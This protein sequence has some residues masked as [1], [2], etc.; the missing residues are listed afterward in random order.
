MFV[1]R[2]ISGAI[3]LALIICGNI[4]GGAAWWIFTG[5]LS[6]TA[7]YELFKVLSLHRTAMFYVTLGIDFALYLILYLGYGEWVPAI[8]M[9]YFVLL[10]GLY[11]IRWPVYDVKMISESLFAFVYAGLCMS[12]LYQVRI[13]EYGI[14]FIWIIFIVSWGCDTF[15]YLTGILIGKH[16][17]PTTLSPKKTIEGCIGGVVGSVVIAF[18]YGLYISNTLDEKIPYYIVFP[19]ICGIGALMS[20]IGDLAASAVKRN[21]DIKDYGKLI[22]GHG[23][24]MDRF[25]SVIYVAPVVYYLMKLYTGGIL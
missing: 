21:M 15:A 5:I 6:I 19:I 25:D 8:V 3:L 16:K 4:I 1:K 20:Q 10:M 11:V 18:F 12:F 14:Y 23:G 24:V 13:E 9:L 7:V 17:L 2:T 22:P